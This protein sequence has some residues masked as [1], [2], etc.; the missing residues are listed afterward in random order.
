MAIVVVVPLEWVCHLGRWSA[1]SAVAINVLVDRSSAPGGGGGVAGLVH[2]RARVVEAGVPAGRG[3]GRGGGGGGGRHQVEGHAANLQGGVVWIGVD[4][5]V[6]R[7]RAGR[8]AQLKVLLL[9]LLAASVMMIWREDAILLV[10]RGHAGGG[11]RGGR[12]EGRGRVRLRPRRGH[13]AKEVVARP[14]TTRGYTSSTGVKSKS[15]H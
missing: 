6:H 15:S 4:V 7:G 3:G 5:P 10:R 13:G 8:L 14:E 11:G 1:V 2:V 12:V 9:L